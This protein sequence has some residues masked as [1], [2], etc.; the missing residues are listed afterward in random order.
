MRSVK[1]QEEQTFERLTK[2]KMSNKPSNGRWL[3]SAYSKR[4]KKINILPSRLGKGNDTFAWLHYIS[5]FTFDNIKHWKPVDAQQYN[6]PKLSWFLSVLKHS[7]CTRIWCVASFIPSFLLLSLSCALCAA[8]NT[9]TSCTALVPHWFEPNWDSASSFNV[10][11]HFFS[12]SNTW[13]MYKSTQWWP[14]H[15]REH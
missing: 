15:L 6:A 1:R 7:H 3:R 8:P 4:K 10:L 11:L 9:F 2:Q 5:A 13:T 12:Q 14:K